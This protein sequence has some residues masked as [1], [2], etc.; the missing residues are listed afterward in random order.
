MNQEIT[1]LNIVINQRLTSAK[2][3]EFWLKIDKYEAIPPFF[4]ILPDCYHIVEVIIFAFVKSV[5]ANDHFPER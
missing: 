4:I 3:T 5:C 2:L 1:E